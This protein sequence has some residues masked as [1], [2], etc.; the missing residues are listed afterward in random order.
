MTF[1]APNL[2]GFYEFIAR[3]VGRHLGCPTEI[4]VGTSY[5]ELACA[6]VAFVCSLPYVESALTGGSPVMPIAAPVLRNPRYE[7]RPIY[8]SDVIVRA[9]SRLRSFDDL[10]G[11]SWSF[12]EPHSQSGYGITRYHLAQRGE[13]CGYFGAVIEAGWHERS[14]RMVLAGEVDA[15]A[16]DSHVLETLLRDDPSLANQLRVVDTLGPSTI[17]PV[18]AARRLPVAVCRA[19]R[20]TLLHVHDEPDAGRHFSEAL[21]ERFVTVSDAD[22]DDVRAMR[23]VAAAADLLVLR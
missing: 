22:Y 8:F 12:N 15:S 1:L 16:I 5:E 6:D 20:Q 17:Q 9:D 23:N 3:A 2:F 11:R 7:G 18:V 10:R 14:V 4:A 19:I 13:K 21:V